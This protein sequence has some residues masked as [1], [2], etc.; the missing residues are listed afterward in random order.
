MALA[1]APDLDA[2]LQQSVPTVTADLV[3]E[4]ASGL[5]EAYCGRRL[6]RT[7]DETTDF[8]VRN[9]LIFLP[10]PPV[11]VTAVTDDGEAVDFTQLPEEGIVGVNL[12]TGTRVAV[13]FDSGPVDVPTVAKAVTLQI[14][15]RLT[16]NADGVTQKS[17]GDV[18]ISYGRAQA[19]PGLTEWEQRSLSSLR[20]PTVR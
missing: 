7:T 19:G 12:T 6:T 20:I 14:A 10:S 4:L 16:T 2:Y 13:T 8:T 11:N 18:S 5:V 9:G 1:E 15:A 17:I 3:L